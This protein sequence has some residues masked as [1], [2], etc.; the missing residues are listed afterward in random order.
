M[1][2]PWVNQPNTD[3]KH[4][5]CWLVSQR[6][7]RC[8]AS[9]LAD[10]G[11]FQPRA[12]ISERLRRFKTCAQAGDAFGASNPCADWRRLRRF[13]T[14][15]QSVDTCGVSKPV[16]TVETHGGDAFGASNPCAEWRYLRRLK[17][18]RRLETPSALQT[19]AQTGDAFG[20][21]KPVRTVETHGGTPAAFQNLCA[22][23]RRLR[24]LKP[25]R[26]LET[27]SAFGQ[28][29]PHD[30]PDK[31]CFSRA[32]DGTLNACG[33]LTS[34]FRSAPSSRNRPNPG[35]RYETVPPV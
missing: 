4:R 27:P 17:P 30:T 34:S 20:V 8:D 10:P 32:S 29:E 1:R 16:R 23:W 21:S 9:R 2:Q 25:V 14:C 22:E 6:F 3:V 31:R 26:R 18:V 24:R 7:Q 19:C 5:R 35:D 15:A 28:R 11:L 13:K 33:V 12:G